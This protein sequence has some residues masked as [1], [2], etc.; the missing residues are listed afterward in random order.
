MT[1]TTV[2]GRGCPKYQE[3][4]QRI[5]KSW[6]TGE[7]NKLGYGPKSQQSVWCLTLSLFIH[8]SSNYRLILPGTVLGT[9]D[10]IMHKIGTTYPSLEVKI[11]YSVNK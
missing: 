3:G 7:A 8:S 10:R 2:Q 6:W 11:K 4:N 9:E 5:M 1:S